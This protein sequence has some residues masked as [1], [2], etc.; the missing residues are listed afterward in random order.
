MAKRRKHI[1]KGTRCQ[2]RK[3]RMKIKQ[4]GRGLP[5][6]VAKGVYQVLK[7]AGRHARSLPKNN[8]F[9]RMTVNRFGIPVSMQRRMYKN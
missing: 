6:T 2:T 1:M 8:L 4:R 3:K 9:R 7:S 5:V